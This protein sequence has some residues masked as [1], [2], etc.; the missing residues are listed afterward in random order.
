MNIQDGT[1]AARPGAASVYESEKGALVLA[2]VVK[3]E[4]GPELKSY[5][6]LANRDGS[7]NTRT[8]DNLKA[9]SGWDG[10]DPFWFM[11]NDLSAAE[12]EVVIANEP[13]FTDP[14]KMFPK[15]KWVNPPGG[16]G[17]NKMPECADRRAVLAKYGAKF[18]AA[19]GGVPIA[20]V[21]AAR[22]AE[23]GD[24]RSAGGPPAVRP[25]PVRPAPVRPAPSVAT[26]AGAWARLCALGANLTQEQREEIWFAAVDATGMDQVDMT[27][28]GWAQ[29]Q[30]AIEARFAGGPGAVPLSVRGVA[31]GPVAVV[32]EENV[33]F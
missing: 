29:V 13:G 18:R 8:V 6:T 3:I 7:I 17:G 23:V 1:Y 4:N 33:P 10:V 27:P 2:L 25:V 31:A 15:V 19:A 26:Q 30:G 9:W 32:D 22:K 14:S 5:H 28:A 11:E 16:G 24:P 12:V 20:P 21:A